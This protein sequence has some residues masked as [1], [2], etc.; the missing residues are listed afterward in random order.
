MKKGIPLEFPQDVVLKF[1]LITG[2]SVEERHL[3]SRRLCRFAQ[4]EITSQ[5]YER[6]ASTDT[7]QFVRT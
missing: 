4:E 3:T 1:S 7:E 5:K 2:H 6:E